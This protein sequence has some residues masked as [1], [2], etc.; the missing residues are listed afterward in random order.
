MS[1]RTS[2]NLTPMAPY[3]LPQEK[4]RILRQAKRLEWIT[5]AFMLTVVGLV[6]A[7]MGQSQAMKAA[8][9]EDVLSMVP[10]IAFLVGHRLARRPPDAW[11]PYGYGRATLIAYIAASFALLGIGAYAFYDSVHTLLSGTRPSVGSRLLFGHLVWEGWLMMGVILYSAIPPV[12]LGRKK[13]KLAKKLN[14]PTLMADAAT[15]RADWLTGLA[16]FLG[17]FGIGYGIWWLDSAMA[18]VIATDI[19]VDGL[20]YLKNACADLMDRAPTPLDD[21][22]TPHPIIE[23]IREFVQHL[24]LEVMALRLRFHGIV[25]TGLLVYRSLQGPAPDQDSL[26]SKLLQQ[27]PDLHDLTL[28]EEPLPES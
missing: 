11:F 14:D 9:L 17:V 16:A 7:V 18:L 8:W 26:H 25:W 22:E 5:L 1:D 13:E 28:V 15:N 21:Y 24:G 12:I 23:Q 6:G 27:F 19:I 4:E 20:H 3:I 2:P 10:P